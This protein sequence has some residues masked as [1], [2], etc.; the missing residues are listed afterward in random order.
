[1]VIIHI[2]YYDVTSC[3]V[4]FGH[5]TSGCHAT[6]GHEQWYILYFYYSKK[7]RRGCTSGHA[8]NI[9]PVMT[10]LPVT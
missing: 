5:V 4:T 2:R 3:D 1:M 10:S 6:F 7:K 9:L 8:Q